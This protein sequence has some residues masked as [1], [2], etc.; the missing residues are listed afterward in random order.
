VALTGT[1]WK[2]LAYNNGK[3]ALQS[4]AAGSEITAVFAE[5]GT[6]SGSSGVNTYSTTYTTEADGAMTVEGSI[7]ATEMA[8]P[9]EFMAQEQAYLAALPQTA[10][11][12]IEGDQLWLRDADGAALAHYAAE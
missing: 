7:A 11:F 2:A 10:T 9:E 8:G 12:S 3:G 1:T 5:D 6:L 4:L